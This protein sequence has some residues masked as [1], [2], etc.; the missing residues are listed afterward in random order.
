[1][2]IRETPPYQTNEAWSAPERIF[3]LPLDALALAV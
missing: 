1:M 2:A 3:S